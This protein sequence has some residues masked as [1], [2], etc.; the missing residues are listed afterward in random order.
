MASVFTMIIS[1]DLPG[2]FYEDG[3]VVAFLTTEP[4]TQDRTPVVPRA[5]VDR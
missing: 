2:R 5:E 3:E 1:G 4:M